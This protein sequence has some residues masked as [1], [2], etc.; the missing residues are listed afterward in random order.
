[1]DFKYFCLLNKEGLWGDFLAPSFSSAP[2]TFVPHLSP[3]SHPKIAS[4]DVSGL[5][6]DKTIEELVYLLVLL[7]VLPLLNRMNS[8]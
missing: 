5:P 8:K 3:S 6:K 2:L 1:M 7:I 4:L